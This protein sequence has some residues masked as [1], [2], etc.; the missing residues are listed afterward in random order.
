M[1]LANRKIAH[2]SVSSRLGAGGMGEV[3]RARDPRL[4]RDVAIKV[5]PA[6][7]ANDD[8]R[9]RR[10]EQ[11]ALATSALN[12]PN[13][14]T[15]YDVG[16]HEGSQYIVEELLDGEDLRA[17]LTRGAID[18]RTAVGY[19]QQIASGLAAAH[20]KNIVHRDLK[21][22]NI[23]ISTDGR[24]KILD[25]GLAKLRP[26]SPAITAVSTVHTHR[27]ATAPGTVMGTVGYMSPEQVRGEE[28]DHRSDI[29]SFGVIL[30]EML[31]GRRTFT[32][33]SAIEIMNAILKE[34]PEDVTETD[35][36]ISPALQR[37]V[38]RCLEKLPERRFQSASDLSFAIDT[39]S[40]ASSSRLDTVAWPA[41]TQT[42][43]HWRSSRREG[44]AWTVAGL[45]LIVSSSLATAYFAGRPTLE[46][47]VFTASILP[48]EKASF[49]SFAVSPDGRWL[50]FTA[51]TGGKTHLWV[52]ALDQLTARVLPDTE[53]A[54]YAFWSPD[55]RALGF[56]TGGRI[57]K[58]AISGGPSQTL[59]SERQIFG[60]T[61][62]Q[63]GTIVFAGRGG[64]WQIPA[65]G[66]DPRP[67]A[68]PDPARQEVSYLYPA[69]LP[70]GLHFLYLITSTQKEHRGIHLGSL[71]GE[72]KQPLLGDDSQALYARSTD[73]AGGYLLF[74]REGLL[75]AQPFD[76]GTRRLAGEPFTVAGL[77]GGPKASRAM[78][79]L[80]DSGVLVF[81]P[82]GTAPS[83]ELIWRDRSGRHIGSPKVMGSAS[84]PALSPDERRF[85]VDR[86]DPHTGNTDLWLYD[87]T[88]E[89]ATRFTFDPAND[90][91]PIWSRDGSRIVWASS[92]AGA[93]H[94]YQKPASGAGTDTLLLESD[95]D[96]IPN[97]WSPD[98]RL[99]LYSGPDPTTRFDV[100]VL[101]LAGD[102]KSFSF[103]P[104]PAG[105]SAAQ[106]SPD[107]RWVAYTSSESGG[108]EVYVQSFPSGG[109]KRQVSTDGG[110]G[111][112]WRGDGRELFYYARDGNLMAVPVKGGATFEAGT[113]LKL[114]GFRSGSTTIV[115][116]PPYAVTADGQRF[117]TNAIVEASVPA[118]LTVMVNWAKPR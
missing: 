110:V 80:S 38:R 18:Q 87:A 116:L 109:G 75:L 39:L 5:L 14:L 111:P 92:R 10:F 89:N 106:L 26:P 83:G 58:V 53:G 71:D 117:L 8:D 23:F 79:S 12:H 69:F 65:A 56:F 3:Y 33:D 24:V 93:F 15:V 85:V 25:F 11:E 95:H 59:C 118:P 94:L 102:G 63:H 6:S 1:T 73:G 100:R 21:P 50:A 9:L 61:W 52:R 57:K 36:R 101:P 32:G 96:A 7:L 88:G 114:F 91:F 82:T 112:V 86:V 27:A 35:S 99:I 48:P 30:H 66:G 72:V 55:S 113:P 76:S 46:T 74:A 20:A 90:S 28:V 44:L 31:R 37:I 49:E 97:D 13:I 108:S 34:D 22:E 60:A 43:G 17:R 98:G 77:G 45:L 103:N 29:F 67:V 54:T 64:L 84:R 104:T 2:Y 115:T 81:D 19:A 47:R 105:E 107:G 16:T 41:S 68:T 51:A 40:A 78:F 4:N 70:D 62:N 42:R